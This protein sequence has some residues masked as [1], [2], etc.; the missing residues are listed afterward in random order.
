MGFLDRLF[1]TGKLHTRLRRVGT[2]AGK[3]IYTCMN[4]SPAMEGNIRIRLG[5]ERPLPKCPVCGTKAR[6]MRGK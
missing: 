1:G 2:R 4:H 6:W 3:G 5:K